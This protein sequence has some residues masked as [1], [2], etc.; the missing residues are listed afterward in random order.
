MVLSFVL[1]HAGCENFG[2]D[3]G[4]S[5][6]VAQFRHTEDARLHQTPARQTDRQYY[7]YFLSDML[8]YHQ[9]CQ[10]AERVADGH[11]RHKAVA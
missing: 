1:H 5:D 10:R 3:P 2:A 9:R 7:Q 8:L 11:G 6:V 4:L